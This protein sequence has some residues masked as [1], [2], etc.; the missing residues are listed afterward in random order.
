MVRYRPMSA[1]PLDRFPEMSLTDRIPNGGT[2][3]RCISDQKNGGKKE[4]VLWKR[5]TL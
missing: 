5:W 1:V 4:D 2:A 3:S